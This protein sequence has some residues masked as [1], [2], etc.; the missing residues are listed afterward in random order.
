ML[1]VVGGF[2]SVCLRNVDRV[3]KGFGFVSVRGVCARVECAKPISISAMIAIL[4]N[5]IVVRPSGRARNVA[6]QQDGLI[7]MFMNGATSKPS[8]L[9][10]Q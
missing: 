3:M 6:N 4:A 2:V 9:R 10:K 7:R 8:A 5:G 1:A